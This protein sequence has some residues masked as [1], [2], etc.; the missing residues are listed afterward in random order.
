MRATQIA[1]GECRWWVTSLPWCHMLSYRDLTHLATDYRE[2]QVLTV[3]LHTTSENPAER[4]MWQAELDHALDALRARVKGGN[5]AERTNLEKAIEQLRQ[6]VIMRRSALRSPG[7]V[8][9][10]SPEEVLYAAPT[11]TVV[12]NV[13]TWSKG[14]HL[15]PLL[16]SASY[17]EPSA[18]LLVDGRNAHLFRYEPPR[19]V[20]RLETMS[21]K[22]DIDAERNLGAPTGAFHRGTRGP[23][24]A[25]E[26]DRLKMA[27][28]QRLYADAVEKAISLAAKEGW[29][30]LTGT[31]RA[32]TAARQQVPS[33]ML[34]RTIT[35]DHVDI[36]VSDFELAQAVTRAI[37][38]REMQRDRELVR[39]ILDEHGARGKGVAGLE[40]ARA[41]L[42]RDGV[43][44]LLLSERFVAG[45]PE[46]TDELVRAAIGHGATVRQ[47]N[48][49]AAADMDA[50]G[51]GVV[52]RLRYN[53]PVGE[54]ATL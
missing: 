14:I 51:E 32:V 49:E 25:D 2:R 30:V 18:V 42:E 5:H 38:D 19:L 34:A 8:V 54:V 27:A 47:V 11:D 39:E 4:N 10:V 35:V 53:M 26:A 15:A 20:E 29:V 44:D 31:T 46:E 21:T 23:T 52:A 3:Y 9:I 50:Q 24:A 7:V 1:S 33:P 6:W 22:E 17:G 28:R 12:P 37:A 16:R 13:A 48:G 40:A 43:A 45:R 41:L 36:H